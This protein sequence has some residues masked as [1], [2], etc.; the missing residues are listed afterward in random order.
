MNA[1]RQLTSRRFA[2]AMGPRLTNPARF[3]STVTGHQM[4][5][6]DRQLMHG[7]F[8]AATVATVGGVTYAA[9]RSGSRVNNRF[10]KRDS[11]LDSSKWFLEGADVNKWLAN[12][13]KN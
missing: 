1:A 3:S 4:S 7:V 11:S 8:T 12:Q 6:K 2:S 5:P 9:T 10:S 13:G